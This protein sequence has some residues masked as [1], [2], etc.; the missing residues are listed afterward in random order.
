MPNVTQPKRS[1]TTLN[2]N[3]NATWKFVALIES[4]IIVFI[5]CVVFYFF[6]NG[7]RSL[8]QRTS[9]NAERVASVQLPL[10]KKTLVYSESGS[11]FSFHYP[12]DW[13]FQADSTYKSASLTNY[14][15]FCRNCS[16]LEK[17]NYYLFMIIDEGEVPGQNT[18]DSVEFV[19][20]NW[21]DQAKREEKRCTGDAPC[22]PVTGS[23]SLDFLKRSELLFPMAD[24]AVEVWS[25]DYYGPSDGIDYRHY[26]VLS[27]NRQYSII[28][29][30]P[31]HSWLNGE[32]S[33]ADLQ[34]PLVQI[35]QTLQ[36]K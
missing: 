31:E 13:K 4:L 16:E 20:Q 27:H 23:S 11:H 22:V 10:I 5:V 9:P 2:T 26:T 19:C 18:S 24:S 15:E 7:V 29:G 30:A 34:H 17:R 12:A 1:T 28:L 36:F 14:P 33:I 6:R 35:I 25:Q 3:T 8:S 32:P 21:I